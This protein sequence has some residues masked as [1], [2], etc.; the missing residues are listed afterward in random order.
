MA[1]LLLQAHGLFSRFGSDTSALQVVMSGSDGN[2][3]QLVTQW[4]VVAR[5]DWL[6]YT[7]APVA[8][9]ARKLAAGWRP[10]DVVSSAAGL[11][12]LEEY[13]A[14]VA[15]STDVATSLFEYVT[16]ATG[17]SSQLGTW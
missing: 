15:A 4:D 5:G 3:Q 16:S 14:E 1:E 12:S 9:L 7:A 11:V 10:R 6:Q 17:G 8:V 2:Q 13:N